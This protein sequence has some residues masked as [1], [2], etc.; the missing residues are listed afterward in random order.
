MA[1]SIWEPVR[2]APLDLLPVTVSPASSFLLGHEGFPIA[3][4]QPD[5]DRQPISALKET[6]SPANTTNHLYAETQP[7]RGD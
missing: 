7:E 6:A 1:S 5:F 2:Y 3:A 4:L